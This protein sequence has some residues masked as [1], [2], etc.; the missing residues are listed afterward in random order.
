MLT[1]EDIIDAPVTVRDTIAS[2]ENGVSF[3]LVG[4]LDAASATVRSFYEVTTR[5]GDK[6]TFPLDSLSDAV[7]VFNNYATG[8][9]DSFGRPTLPR[10]ER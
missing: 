3:N 1:P 7:Q 4:T 2:S 8:G 10:G 5:S 6:C 9:P